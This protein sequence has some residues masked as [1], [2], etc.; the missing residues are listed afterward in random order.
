LK[1]ID[2]RVGEDVSMS[3]T[4]NTVN[5]NSATNADELGGGGGMD[6]G[7]FSQRS[8]SPN[9]NMTIAG[10]TFRNNV[11]DFDGGGVELRVISDSENV[12]DPLDT[13]LLDAHATIDFSNNLVA[14]NDANNTQ[15][16]GRG[17]GLLVFAQAFGSATSTANLDRNTIADNSAQQG[18]GGIE[19]ESYTGFDTFGMDEGEAFVN[20]NSSVI[21]GNF[22]FGIGGPNTMQ[23][24]FQPASDDP[25]A[26]QT[27]NLVVET[28][29]SSLFSNDS[30]IE[31]WLGG[32]PYNPDSYNIFDDP[33][34]DALTYVP[35]VCSPTLDAADPTF[36]Y[37]LEPAPNGGAANM[38][39]T[40]G[41][42]LAVTALADPSGDSFVDGVDILRIAVAF[43]SVF[44]GAGN[45]RYDASA[46]LDGDGAV[47]GTDLALLTPVYG[48]SCQ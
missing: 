48:Q 45:D 20:V 17:G 42:A 36:D 8:L 27:L 43:G 25:T 5:G 28:T 33:L 7:F 26:G 24:V 15:D 22:G 46:D 32:Q 47:D 37:S 21:Y 11:A 14:L 44:G 16:D 6:A 35:G 23:G 13:L 9:M 3:V 39:H 29:Y 38:G 18:S 10:N 34:L 2:L 1:A 30:D 12:F 40:G 4:N 31:A 41:T 19:I